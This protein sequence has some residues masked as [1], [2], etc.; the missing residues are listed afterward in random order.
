MRHVGVCKILF[1]STAATYGFQAEM[2]LRESSPQAPETPYG[3]SKLAAEWIIK[4]YAR[5]YGFGYA[6]LRYFNASGADADGSF[7]EDRRHES[8]LI[9]LI[10]QAA[11]GRRSKVLIYGNDY[12]TRDGSCVRDYVHTADLAQAHQLA[13]E[14]L[15]PGMGRVYNLG[16][17]T[18]AT[19][20]EVLRACEEI[21]GSP[22][23]H[24]ITSRR[25]GDPAVL[26][27]SPQR[28][29]DELGWSPSYSSIQDIVRTAWTWHR[30]NP[31]GF[32]RSN[33]LAPGPAA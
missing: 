22:I 14:S 32:A 26:I 11:V 18:G 29:I 20:L 15:K 31:S 10:L 25:P 17:G 21:S 4:D 5:A 19:V 24:E 6:V 27:A 2:P 30:R 16:S 33:S 8:H 9:P 3:C 7:G 28:I 1:S 23:P 13:L 12:P